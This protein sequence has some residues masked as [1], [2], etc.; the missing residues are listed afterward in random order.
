MKAINNAIV[1]SDETTV[2]LDGLIDPT[3]YTTPVAQQ[4]L[5]LMKTRI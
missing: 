3:P 1:R 2:E 5:D 4:S